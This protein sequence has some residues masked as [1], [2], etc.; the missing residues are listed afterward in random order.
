[1]AASTFLC[2]CC[3]GIVDKPTMF[4]HQPGANVRLF[5]PVCPAFAFTRL[6]EGDDRDEPYPDWLIGV[7]AD[8][9]PTRGEDV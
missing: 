5:F 9:L 3:G 8:R 2:H 1:M 7:H 4:S 6:T